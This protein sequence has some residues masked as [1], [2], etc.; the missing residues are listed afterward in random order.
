[1][2]APLL[3]P[4]M[5]YSGGLLIVHAFRTVL[6]LIQRALSRRAGRPEPDKPELMGSVATLF[7][8]ALIMVWVLFL[9]SLIFL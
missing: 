7:G 2:I 3:K 6:Y 5:I 9:L 1:M 8:L 4:L